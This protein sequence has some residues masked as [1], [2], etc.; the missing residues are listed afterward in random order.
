MVANDLMEPHA[1]VHSDKEGAISQACWL[2]VSRDSRV[3]GTGPD[4]WDFRFR[5]FLFEIQSLDQTLGQAGSRFGT[6]AS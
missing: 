4:F 1:I 6:V 2:C 3:N 5:F